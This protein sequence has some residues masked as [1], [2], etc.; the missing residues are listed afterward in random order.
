MNTLESFNVI[1]IY[2]SAHPSDLEL[3]TNQQYDSINFKIR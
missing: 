1:F 2:F 3:S